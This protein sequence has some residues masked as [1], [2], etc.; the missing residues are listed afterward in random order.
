M[1][2]LKGKSFLTLLDFN[3]DEINFLLDYAKV[4]KDLKKCGLS[5]NL[6]EGKNIVLL[7]E[8]TSTRT[9]SAFEVAGYDEGAQVTFLNNS[10]FGVKETVEDTARVLGRIYDGIEF[11]GNKQETVDI[12]SEES[13]VPVWN[14]LTDEFH[15]TQI[16]ADL[17]TIKEHFGDLNNKK[18][19]FVGDTRNNVANSLMIGAAKLGLDFAAV[20]PKELSPDPELLKKVYEIAKESGSEIIVTDNIEEG[21]KDADVIYTDIW[22]SMGEEDQIEERIELLQDYQVNKNLMDLTGKDSTI[23]L[24]CLPSY[25]DNKTKFGKMV[26]DKYGIS[27]MEVT[28]EVFQ[29]PQSLV[30]DQAENRLHTIKAVVCSTLTDKLNYFIN[31]QKNYR[32]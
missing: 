23:F 12:L 11:R 8:K 24:H 27:E 30:F 13:G 10:Q 18:I 17:L 22:V 26:E 19:V 9:R 31:E 20:G 21:V 5:L 14:G 32:S 6:L 1:I 16:L 3:A 29:S 28:D 15:P 4:L 2:D 25:H 7:F